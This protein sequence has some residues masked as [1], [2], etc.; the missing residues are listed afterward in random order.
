MT[1]LAWLPLVFLAVQARQPRGP[2]IDE[3]LRSAPI[4]S[5]RALGSGAIRVTLDD[6]IRKHDAQ[7]LAVHNGDPAERELY[8]LDVA[9]YELDKALDLDLVVPSVVRTING[10]PSAVSWWVD[11]VA[12]AEVERRRRQIQPPDP[13]RW[14]RQM[15]SVRIFDELISNMYRDISPAFY[16]SVVWDNLLITTDWR[17]VLI[18]H[19]HSFRTASQLEHPESLMRC[20]RALIGKLRD[21]NLDGFKQKLGAYLAAAQL[22]ALETRRELLVKHFDELIARNGEGAVLYEASR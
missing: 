18:D 11:D 9:A 12:M 8:I 17:I 6:G 4:V 13:E 16:L 1:R 3:F 22:E 5:E 7:V 14:A 20:D 15:Q 2:E 19:T 21:L 10:Q